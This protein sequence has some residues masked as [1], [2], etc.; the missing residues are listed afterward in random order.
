MLIVPVS[1][2]V[3]LVPAHPVEPALRDRLLL[4]LLE[5]VLAREDAAA[6]RAVRIESDPM[7]TQTRQELLFDLPLTRVVM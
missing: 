6:K 3:H 1:L 4:L 7:V 2:P 5:L